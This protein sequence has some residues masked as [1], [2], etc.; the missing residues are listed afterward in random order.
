VARY[1]SKDLTVKVDN[2]SGTLVNLSAYVDSISGLD[3]E[4]ILEED[5]HTFGDTWAE[6]LSTGMK[7]VGEVT[8][9]GF[10]DDT[11]STGPEAILNAIGDQRTLEIT[12]G[13]TKVTTVET[14]IKS[15]SRKP[16]RG[17]LTRFTAVLK[18]TGS[19]TDA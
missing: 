6:A 7:R 18:P 12:W 16:S 17:Q 2:S 8:L 10:Y 19:L 14:L 4:A 9:E 15:Y 5:S 13:G 3:L 1:A 11:S